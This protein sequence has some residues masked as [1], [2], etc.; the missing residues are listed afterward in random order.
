[1]CIR[2]R[3]QI[4]QAYAFIFINLILL[5]V[6]PLYYQVDFLVYKRIVSLVVVQSYFFYIYSNLFR[7]IDKDKTER[8]EQYAFR[9]GKACL[10]YTSRCV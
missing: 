1:M 10:L 7:T 3:S 2:D 6:I 5:A 9:S 4:I 8:S